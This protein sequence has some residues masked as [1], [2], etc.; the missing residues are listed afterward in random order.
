MIVYLD[1]TTA[2]RFTV[3]YVLVSLL[4]IMMGV[5]SVLWFWI[6]WRFSTVSLQDLVLILMPFVA[7]LSTYGYSKMVIEMRQNLSSGR[8]MLTLQQ[9]HIQIDDRVIFLKDIVKIQQQREVTFIH[10]ADKKGF[11][12]ILPYMRGEFGHA[13]DENLIQLWNAQK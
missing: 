3:K 12:R 6:H 2:R 9:D 13:I 1:P 8:P 11:A 4:F 7:A 5:I 10:L